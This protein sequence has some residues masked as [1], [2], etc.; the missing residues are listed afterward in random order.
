M[1]SYILTA[2]VNPSAVNPLNTEFFDFHNSSMSSDD[3]LAHHATGSPENESSVVTI[4][5]ANGG[6]DPSLTEGSNSDF[7]ESEGVLGTE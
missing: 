7:S 1:T 6:P 2:I 3:T 5:R 4:P